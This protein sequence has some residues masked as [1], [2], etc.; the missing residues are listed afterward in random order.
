MK[1][2]FKSKDANGIVDSI[3]NALGGRKLGDM[4][5]FAMEGDN[6]VVTISKLGT[7]QLIF[8]KTD[9]EDGL[10]FILSEEKIAFT[11][12]AFKS[13]VKEKLCRVVEQAGGKING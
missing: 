8:T 10:V 4:V 6:L 3:R 13:E 5:S 1:F 9:A 7:S 11:H 2:Q 12:R